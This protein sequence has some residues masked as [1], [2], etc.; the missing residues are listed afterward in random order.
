MPTCVICLDVLKNPACL[1]CGHVFCSECIVQLV[2]NVHPYV[3]QHFCPTC[4]Q[5]YTITTVDP[6]LV[7]PNL[8]L[9]VSPCIRKLSLDYS[10]PKTES[11]SEPVEL[12]CARLRAENES[13]KQCCNVWCNRARLHARTTLGLVSMVRMSKDAAMA[14]KAE[15]EEL[16]KKYN[17]LKRQLEH[18][19]D[20]T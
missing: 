18:E 3:N 4:R 17:S 16:E 9:H 8:Q 5:Q 20:N 7:P 14:I 10:K 13:L 12:E 1:P 2:R 19:D 11:T 15:K 6:K